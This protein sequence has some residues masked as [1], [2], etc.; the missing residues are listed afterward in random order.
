MKKLFLNIL[1]FLFAIVLHAQ[2]VTVNIHALIQG[3]YRPSLARMVAV[4]DAVNEPNICDSMIVNIVDTTPGNPVLFTHKSVITTNGYGS[5]NFTN[6]TLNRRYF[7]QLVH[8]NSL[9]VYTLYPVSFLSDSVFYDFT[10]LP[11]QFCGSADITQGVALICTGDIN[12]DQVIDGTD[13]NLWEMASINKAFGYIPEDIN[14]DGLV[15]SLDLDMMYM[16]ILFVA[17][18]GSPFGCASTTGIAGFETLVPELNVFPNPT[19]YKIT[20]ETNALN[21]FFEFNDISGKLLI[22]DAIISSKF[23]IDLSRFNSGMYFLTV[24]NGNQQIHR[25][26]IKQ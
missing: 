22:K 15:D 18:G 8:R 7:I 2:N 12:Q 13:M 6:V 11:Q 24:Y 17:V 16:N 26:I 9:E 1:F 4:I 10:I 3:F 19:K 14:G 21:S 23:E 20:I 5:F 25:K